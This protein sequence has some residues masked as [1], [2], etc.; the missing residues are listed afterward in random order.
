M[1]R[2]QTR[3]QRVHARVLERTR[4]ANNQHQHENA[5]LAL[6]AGQAPDRQCSGRN[7]F[8]RLAYARDTTPIVA[9]HYLADHQGQ[10]EHRQELGEPHEAQI[11]GA[12]GQGIYLPANSDSQHLKS[13]SRRHS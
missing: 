6:P 3:H 2:N 11:Q 9:V 4:C 1:T 8:Y 10:Q 5:L 13:E 12:A 7:P